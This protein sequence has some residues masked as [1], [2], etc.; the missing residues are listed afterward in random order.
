V[1]K[2][3]KLTF[4][5][6]FMKKK[7]NFCRAVIAIALIGFVAV[8]SLTGCEDGTADPCAKGHSFPAWIA[9]TCTVNG[10]TSRTCKNCTQKDTRADGWEKL[11]HEGVGTITAHC[12]QEGF[13]GTGPC[14]RVA[15][16]GETSLPGT[17]TG[18]DLT[19][20]GHAWIENWQETEEAKC[21][22][23]NVMTR[24]CTRNCGKENGTQTKSTV[25]ALLHDWDQLDGT[26]STCTTKGEGNRECRL[27]EKTEFGELDIDPA[28]HDYSAWTPSPAATCL[29]AGSETRT[30][31]RDCGEI[32]HT[33]TQEIPIDDNAH[34]SSNCHPYIITGSGT[35]FRA[36]KGTG[37]AIIGGTDKQIISTV[38]TAIRTNAAI[39][40]ASQPVTI[41]FGS[42]GSTLDIGTDNV[43][44]NSSGSA[45]GIITLAGKITSATQSVGTVTLGSGVSVV[46]NDDNMEIISTDIRNGFAVYNESGSTLTVNNGTIRSL[47]EDGATIYNAGN[48]TINIS[49]GTVSATKGAAV[50]NAGSSR[51]NISGTANITSAIEVAYGGTIMISNS[52][53]QTEPRLV[54]TG[55]TVRNT[56]D[57]A[58]ARVINNSSTSAVH[59]LGGTVELTDAH[60]DA[61]A[62]EGTNASGTLVLGGNPE[63]TGSIRVPVASNVARLIAS[64]GNN[65]TNNPAP[66]FAP[67]T[68]RNYA[69]YFTA[70]NYNAVPFTAVTGGA[71]HLA[72]F[73][74]HATATNRALA[75]NNGNIEVQCAAHN[76]QN[77]GDGTDKCEYCPAVRERAKGDAQLTTFYWANEKDGVLYS[78]AGNGFSLSR[79]AGQFLTI[80]ASSTADYSNQ[81]WFINSVLQ[82][83]SNGQADFTFSSVGKA[84]GTY[85][86]D[87]M[88]E[89]DGANYSRAFT[90]TVTN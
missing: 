45:W 4:K 81:M 46:I 8:L 44:F 79:S 75:A 72:R 47:G 51:I 17:S 71:A 21:E 26:P 11:G 7:N 63:I 87:L 14:I 27:C 78:T 83:A 52:G 53:S 68:A 55:G 39:F 30:C 77:Q 43:T 62:I 66:A 38:I 16:C 34:V 84:N 74:L 41:Q 9:P 69:L 10:N 24:I 58:N 3:N 54:I 65:S 36:R 33:E 32:G 89:K 67:S 22:V 61:F 73:S 48:S 50:L 25:D 31:T 85:R 56:S 28:K 49:G 57:N 20:T 1:N 40:G 76:W 59:I 19:P 29:T 60:A 12:M 82:T 18:F 2:F 42:G 80:N 88:V 64:N 86:I 15:D 13:T 5:E 6:S 90:V 37:D 23:P 70:A 35:Q